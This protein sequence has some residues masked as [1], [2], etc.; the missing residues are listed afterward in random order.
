VKQSNV[1]DTRHLTL[2]NMYAQI[3]VCTLQ[4]EIRYTCV[5]NYMTE[6]D[7]LIT[8]TIRVEPFYCRSYYPFDRVL[9]II[10]CTYQFIS[11]VYT[12]ANTVYP[13]NYKCRRRLY[14]KR[15]YLYILY[16]IIHCLHTIAYILCRVYY[17][18]IIYIIIV[19]VYAS[20]I[21]K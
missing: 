16:L 15:A 5:Y 11:Y 14:N 17:I 10:M 8:F 19:V 3:K 6:I 1:R 20:C 13:L 18:N 9:Y 2:Y 4:S 21:S 7:I 12:E